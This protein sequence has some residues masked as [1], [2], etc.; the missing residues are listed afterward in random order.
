MH[1]EWG[2]G[3]VQVMQAVRESGAV[4]RK[5]FETGYAY[6]K[7]ALKR[8]DLSGGRFGPFWDQ[9]VFSKVKARLGGAYTRLA[10]SSA[11]PSAYARSWMF[12]MWSVI[13]I[14]AISSPVYAPHMVGC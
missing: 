4:S 12:S 1:R 10:L 14:S 6:K 9:L 5:L 7:A 11:E 3:P 13:S 8:G 2:A